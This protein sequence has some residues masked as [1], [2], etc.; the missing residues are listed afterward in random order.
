MADNKGMNTILIAF[1]LIVIGVA[2]VNVISDSVFENVSPVG[3]SNETL[4]ITSLKINGTWKTGAGNL[5]NI[6]QSLPLTLANDEIFDIIS[7]VNASAGGTGADILY[8]E[9]VDWNHTG[10]T[11][12]FTNSSAMVTNNSNATFVTYT[13]K[14]DSYVEHSTARTLLDL[15]PLFFVIALFLFVVFFILKDS[16]FM[17]RIRGAI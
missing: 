6:N 15:I 13:Y 5:N 1:V 2:L 4:D 8:I 9:G 3:M 12:T 11:I 7:V 14:T 16:D 10:D 17:D